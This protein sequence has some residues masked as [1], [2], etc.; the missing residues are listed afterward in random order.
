MRSSVASSIASSAAPGEAAAT[1]EVG[2]STD[3][4]RDV[5]KE[6]QAN[7]Q[8]NKSDP[9]QMTD[10]Q[11]ELQVIA[12]QGGGLFLSLSIF[13]IIYILNLCAGFFKKVVRGFVP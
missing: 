3:E 7:S 9:S 6:A 13:F 10:S 11:K 1:G 8:A 5:S 4:L 12:E 2:D